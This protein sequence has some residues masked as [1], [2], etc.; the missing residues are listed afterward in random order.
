VANERE[1]TT[2]GDWWP[3]LVPSWDELENVYGASLERLGEERREL[4]RSRAVAQPFGTY[5]QPLRLQ[6]AS[7]E[8]S[9]NS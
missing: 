3:L 1:V 7:R 6:N 4:M 2:H 8:I 5:T 9:P